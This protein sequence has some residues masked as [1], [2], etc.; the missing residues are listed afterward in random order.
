MPSTGKKNYISNVH[1]KLLYTDVA[2]CYRR[3]PMSALLEYHRLIQQD[4]G[5]KL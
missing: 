5:P 2:T 4:I 3:L 1:F